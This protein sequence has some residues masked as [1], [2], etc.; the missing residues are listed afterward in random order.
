MAAPHVAPSAAPSLG[1][2]FLKDKRFED[3][4]RVFEEDLKKE[5]GNAGASIGLAEVYGHSGD[6][7]HAAVVL[8]QAATLNPSNAD[9]HV[10]LSEIYGEMKRFQPAVDESME[11]LQREVSPETGAVL[12]YNLACYEARL[13]NQRTALWW[14]RQALDAGFND[15]EHLQNDPDLESLRATAAYRELLTP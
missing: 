3:A 15:Y 2:Q 12:K 6:L 10:A 5:P 9:V 8:R 4:R 14:L 13:G 11:A 7:E 1:W